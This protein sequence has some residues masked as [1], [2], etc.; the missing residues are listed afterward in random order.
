M[1]DM[2]ARNS[3]HKINAIAMAGKG[4]QRHRASVRWCQSCEPSVQRSE[5]IAEELFGQPSIGNGS[6]SEIFFS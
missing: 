3:E 4:E 2:Y 1:Y 5:P 6:E